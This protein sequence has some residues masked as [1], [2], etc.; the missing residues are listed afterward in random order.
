MKKLILS[1][2][3][4]ILISNLIIAQE[5]KSAATLSASIKTE[6]TSES[7]EKA[8]IAEQNNTKE[9]AF[10][11]VKTLG[12]NEVYMNSF[13]TIINLKKQKYS[14]TNYSFERKKT[15]MHEFEKNVKLV[16]DEKVL[17][18]VKSNQEL[19]DYLFG[20]KSEK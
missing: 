2:S 20:I 6:E 15:L 14:G 18:S 3:F 17:M 11:F 13:I 5:K 19:N 7:I 4:L 16:I 1:F 12:L 8:M 10:K 9:I